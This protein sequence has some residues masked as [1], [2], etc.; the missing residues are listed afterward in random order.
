MFSSLWE[1]FSTQ[2]LS[3]NIT[4]S[5]VL[6]LRKI[7]A[8]PKSLYQLPSKHRSRYDLRNY[9]SQCVLWEEIHPTAKAT[10][11]VGLNRELRCPFCNYR[12]FYKKPITKQTILP[13][14][15][16]TRMDKAI[17]PKTMS[18]WHGLAYVFISRF[19]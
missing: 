9:H 14:F 5:S 1:S 10:Q 17:K 19:G 8:L 13:D 4:P 3:M 16:G 6:E 12:L 2:A 15:N 7:S 18:N 11:Y